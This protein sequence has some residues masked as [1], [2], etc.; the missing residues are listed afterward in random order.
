MLQDPHALVVPD[1]TKVIGKSQY[2]GREYECVFIPK[3]VVEIQE[4]AFAV[5]EELKEVVI[6]EGSKLKTIGRA[7]FLNCSNLTRI[8]FPEGLEKIGLNAF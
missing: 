2:K 8:T 5:C 3:S 4:R 7:A 6:E 1:G